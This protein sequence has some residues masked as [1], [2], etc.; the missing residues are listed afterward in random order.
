MNM[1]IQVVLPPEE[2]Q[3]DLDLR[4]G[5]ANGNIYHR[6]PG[7][8]GVHDGQVMVRLKK[9]RFV[10]LDYSIIPT[11]A[12]IQAAQTTVHTTVP[13]GAGKT[14]CTNADCNK[15]GVPVLIYDSDP[16]EP[17]SL[18]MRSGLCF[19]C[20]R[21]LN[22]KR[23]TQRK[24]PSDIPRNG[25]TLD[26][27]V[28]VFGSTSIPKKFKMSPGAI[29]I[30]PMEGLRPLAEGYGFN[31]IGIDLQRVVSEIAMDSQRLVDAVSPHHHHHHPHPH[32]H[33]HHHD[34]TMPPPPPPDAAGIAPPDIAATAAAVA[35]SVGAEPG[36][37]ADDLATSAAIEAT[38][39]GDKDH[40]HHHH[41]EHE[42]MVPT[43][44]VDINALYDKA[45]RTMNKGI[46]LLCQW[47]QSWDSA[48]AAAV[49]QESVDHGLADAVA[50][51]AAV[52]AA[53]A[54]ENQSASMASL[55]MG[56]GHDKKD[57]GKKSDDA[58][59]AAAEAAVADATEA[60][61]EAYEV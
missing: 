46:Y 32:P 7:L 3:E 1:G 6:K 24:R 59:L 55:L 16:N 8:E 17:A 25:Q 20:Q 58:V 22:E 27:G 35:A 33:E 26:G 14:S 4:L 21:N 43:A 15:V 39:N 18:Y 10:I 36:T 57:D 13:V 53:A 61:V 60:V 56:P 37:L 54:Q 51:A 28:T 29:V 49:A 34:P 42:V 2:Y 19:T 12:D 5:R 11:E 30:H 23:R 38:T 41:D 31:E 52:A 48:V 47:K 40:E 9:K 50:S 44:S 45:Y